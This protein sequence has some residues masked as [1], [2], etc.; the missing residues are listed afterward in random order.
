MINLLT[1]L[2]LNFERF[3]ALDHYEIGLLKNL[4]PVVNQLINSE[5]I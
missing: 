3:N 4:H 2:K 5:I 1:K